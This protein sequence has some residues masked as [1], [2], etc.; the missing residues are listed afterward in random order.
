M[1]RER[2]SMRKIS[3]ILRLHA[4]G[5]SARQIAM[6]AG[7]ARST[8]ADCLWRAGQA[9]LS[10]PLPSGLDDALLAQRLYPPAPV[11]DDAVPVP[12]WAQ[13]QAELQR[14][15][16]TLLLLWQEY[17]AATPHGYQYSRFCDL[18]RAWNQTQDVVLRQTHV[19]G[20]KCC[21][22]YAG[23]TAEVV[24]PQT[25]EIRAAQIFVAVLGHS[26]YTYAEATWTQGAADWCA[27]QVRALDFFG[28]APAAIIPDNL[29]AGVI[30]PDRFD[31][32]L[33]PAYQ[34]FAAHYGL[35]ILPARVRKPRDKAK[36][37]VG[38]QIVERWIL[39]RLRNLTFF[40]LAALNQAIAG[41]VAELNQK[42]FQKR[43]GSRASVFAA[44]DQPAL[45]PLPRDR[46]DYAI[47]KKAK[48]HL[49]YHVEVERRY[50]S[51]PHALV[52]KTV[53]VRLTSSTIEIFN[54]GQRV[55]AHLRSPL[56]G[57]FTTQPAH[58][59]P[60]HQ[61]IV[62]LSHEK[63]LRQAEAIGPSTV[64]V[65]YAQIH[66][67]K[68]PEHALRTS[69]GVLRLAKDFSDEALEAACTRA[70]TLKST[71]YRAIRALIQAPPPVTPIELTLPLPE[72]DNLRGPTYFH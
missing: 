16:V 45:R 26:S 11:R 49:D 64:G 14:K 54:Q 37:E 23:P 15:G 30:K 69:L 21:V 19:P 68:H 29:K 66:A 28:G 40:S 7:A 62:D 18:Y 34:E 60:R 58:R 53:E 38:V 67:R 55:A 70:L 65:L 5:L 44:V 47:W 52:G 51:V 50:Y 39:A 22:D 35:T 17:K 12:D 20:D 32:D 3:E 71:S 2:L 48:V 46:Y 9:G 10:W 57:T 4:A 33:H 42:P 61:A 27:S 8:V 56:Q 24:D 72:H 59:P 6:S 36:V 13:L 43:E 63:L 25:A 31:P 1:P 41:L